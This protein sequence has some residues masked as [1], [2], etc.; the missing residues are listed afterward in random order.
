MIGGINM[1]ITVKLRVYVTF[2]IILLLMAVVGTYSLYSMNNV[3]NI[4]LDITKVQVPGLDCAQ[5]ISTQELNYRVLQYQH[6]VAASTQAKLAV[7]EEMKD[8]LSKMDELL[9]VYEGQVTPANKPVLDRYKAAWYKFLEVDKRILAYSREG[10]SAEAMNLVNGEAEQIHKNIKEITVLLVDANSDTMKASNIQAQ[11]TFSSAQ[12]MMGGMGIVVFLFC[13]ASAFYISSIIVKA[14]KE[15]LRVSEKVAAGDLNQRVNISTNDEFG[16]LA[17]SYNHT[18][19]EL[20]KLISRIKDTSDQVAASSEELTASAEQSTEVV[21]Q[22]AQSITEVAAT[23]SRQLEAVESATSIVQGMSANMEEISSTAIV[24]ARQAEKAAE[25]AKL[26]GNAVE[27]AVKQMDSIGKTVN[28]SAM[29]VSKLG[30]K[31]KEIGQIV[32]T[33][34]GIAGQTNL[35]A[36]NAAIEAARAGE[37]GKGFAV[38]AEEV[39]KL[40]EQSG[41]AAEKISKMIYEIQTETDKAVTAMDDGTKEVEIGVEVVNETGRSFAEIVGMVEEVSSEVKKIADTIHEMALQTQKIVISV[42]DLESASKEVA[43]ESEA[44]SA[45]TEEQAASMSEIST[46]SKGLANL[47]HQL[48]L[49]A[50][51]FK[52]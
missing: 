49:A 26:G 24:S 46:S 31:S 25:T 52:I 11:E 6:V 51:K 44:V 9:R 22:V 30:S 20:K 42:Q 35:L 2:G 43:A 34:S 37:Q 5:R 28:S 7:E 4:V 29:V 38:V 47:A 12:T 3:N 39:R 40:A 18:L 36:L 19:E 15:V 45:A 48:Q 27:K 1:N 10:K 17:Q 33:I 41:V 32:D 21:G 14:I 13:I 16:Q 8:P 50:S 23:S